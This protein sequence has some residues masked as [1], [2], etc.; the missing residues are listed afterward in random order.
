ME[1]TTSLPLLC[2]QF[3]TRCFLNSQQVDS[4][5]HKDQLVRVANMRR[6]NR[7]KLGQLK[8]MTGILVLSKISKLLLFL[9]IM[10]P[11]SNNSMCTALFWIVPCKLSH[12]SEITSLDVGFNFIPAYRYAGQPCSSIN[13][14]P[15]S[16][17]GMAASYAASMQAI[18]LPALPPSACAE[19]FASVGYSGKAIIANLD[20]SK[21][22]QVNQVRSKW[23]YISQLAMLPKVKAL[24]I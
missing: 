3:C 8:L 2:S 9:S 23:S 21:F 14:G 11:S 4:D 7:R 6:C 12:E 24:Q 13:F 1:S 19:T 16:G 18:G 17:V 20:I 22:S 10:Q 15:F 5:W